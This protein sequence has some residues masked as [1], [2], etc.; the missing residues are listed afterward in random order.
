[1]QRG[2]NRG[3]N[4]LKHGAFSANVILPGEDPEEF[5]ALHQSLIDEWQ[6]AGRLEEETIHTLAE[7]LWRKNRLNGFARVQRA[8]HVLH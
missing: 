5:N 2:L 8:K 3:P 4:A 7:C 6:P 1:V